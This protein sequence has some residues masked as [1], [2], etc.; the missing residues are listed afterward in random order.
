M[1]A[2]TA[3]IQSLPQQPA[4]PMVAY[5]QSVWAEAKRVTWPTRPQILANTLTVILLTAV[6]SVGLFI[7][8]NSFRGIIWVLTQW[9]PR[10]AGWM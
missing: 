3:P 5:L 7:I 9:L 1:S 6:F 4:S 8:D 10:V 2:P